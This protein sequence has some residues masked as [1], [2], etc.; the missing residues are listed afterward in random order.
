MSSC[1]AADDEAEYSEPKFRKIIKNTKIEYL[2]EALPFNAVSN[3]FK[4]QDRLYLVAFD[5]EEKSF[6]HVYDI[7][8]GEKQYS[9]V[10]LGNGPSEL[11][12]SAASHLEE[13][14]GKLYFFDVTSTQ[15]LTF[16]LG[17]SISF[18]N[19]TVTDDS[20]LIRYQ[21][22]SADGSDIS[23]NGYLVPHPKS[24]V[25]PAP[26]II[27]RDPYRDTLAVYNQYPAISD[28]KLLKAM[29][30]SMSVSLSPDRKHLAIAQ[31][32]GSILEVFEISEES[33]ERCAVKYFVEPT[34]NADKNTYSTD[35]TVLGFSDIYLTNKYV[36]GCYDGKNYGSSP[37]SEHFNSIAVFDFD[38]DPVRLY[39]LGMRVRNLCVDESAKKIY[40]ILQSA[41]EDMRLASIDI[42]N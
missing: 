7:K 34:K 30:L 16:Q 15:A 42:V 13:E 9:A 39:E 40:C 5:F 12:Y 27:K 10:K 26:R 1:G 35:D 29:D 4:Y 8:T 2:S 37:Q 32:F 18:V 38:G 24:K 23:I 21:Y 31:V 20:V 25:R 11:R 3:F 41:N 6:L 19:K 28:P 17:D 36:Y 22:P 33:I 14:T